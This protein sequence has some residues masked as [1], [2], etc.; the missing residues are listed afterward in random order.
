MPCQRMNGHLPAYYSGLEPFRALFA[1]GNPILTY[2]KLGP[3]PSGVR[4]KGMYL[5]ESLF[6]RQ[7]NE[8]RE[9]G[10]MT[11]SLRS[12]V[13]PFSGRRVVITFD[14]AYLNVLRFGLGPLA[15]NGFKAIQ[16]V[17]AD[18]IGKLNTWDMAL[19]EAPEQLMDKEQ[20]SEWLDAGHDIGSHTLSHPY[21][22]RLPPARAQEEIEAS[23]KRLEDAFARPIE[24]FCYPFGDWND[25]V[26][27][28][29]IEAGY[30]TA[31][32]TDSGINVPGDSVFTLKR[33]TARYRSRTLQAFLG[34]WAGRGH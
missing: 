22:T 27:D 16:F 23:K 30:K 4:L 13:E 34:K 9:E 33:L 26:Q 1:Q 14:D 8:L 19:G 12:C 11:G 2:H 10:Y 24:H 5:S 15:A 31:C 18:R 25:M 28:L 17:V 29:V 20:L 32:T 21:L 3:R 6:V 7:L